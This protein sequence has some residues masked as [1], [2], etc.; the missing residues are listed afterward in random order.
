MRPD[1][2]L[3][4]TRVI[5]MDRDRPSADCVAVSH[6]RIV[7]VG[8]GCSEGVVARADRVIDCRGR[9]VA[10]GFID[11]HMHLQAFAE[12]LETVDVGPRSG[13]RS[14]ADLLD[15]L[16]DAAAK[17]PTG[18][19]LRCGGYREFHLR[20]RRHPTR[21]DLDRA[22][23]H[24]PVKLAHA[25][26]HAHVL[27]SMALR[28]VGI[29][30]E[31]GDP[32][33]GYLD[34][35]PASGEPTGILYGMGEFLTR[36]IPPLEA[37]RLEE[38][39]R[40]AD[41]E[42]SR[43]G[44]TTIQD[45]SSRNDIARWSALGGWQS[46]GLLRTRVV[47]MQGAKDFLAR[48]RTGMAAALDGDCRCIGAVKIV[49]DETTGRLHP[50]PEALGALVGA[51]HRQGVQVAIHAL[52]EQAIAA[53]C[54]AIEQALRETPRPG[55]RHRI[56]HCAICPPPLADRIAAAGITVV[57]QPPFVYF[58]G[59]RY[60]CTVPLSRLSC[61]YPAATLL[62]RGIVVAGSSDCPIV[63]TSPLAGI[64]A[65]V[66]RLSE[67]D[68]AV[69]LHEAVSPHAALRLY[70]LDAARACFA[71]SYLGSIT[72]GK[73]ADLVVL[74]DDPTAAPPEGIDRIRVLMTLRGG[75]IV[76]RAQDF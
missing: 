69:A 10:P 12:S 2:V 25:S 33:G 38:G 64:R 18:E 53:A 20:E 40:R 24:H 71:E 4:N 47:M 36:R 28:C 65:A 45:A 55:H 75:D 66:T 31:T 39:I 54:T 48:G 13:V 41:A 74:S 16:R 32:D 43:T 46:R 5:T 1:I 22:V 17:Q 61:L 50:D 29:T 15:V 30:G 8:S 76:W 23:P 21:G 34:R 7:H 59:D 27:N 3:V 49:L 6:G 52:E 56:E 68:K 26:G 70:T 19:W 11:A 72:V 63:P 42:L 37:A 60:L 9:T 51:A 67:T 14:I 73:L 57:T 62:A 58:H 35:D 44:L